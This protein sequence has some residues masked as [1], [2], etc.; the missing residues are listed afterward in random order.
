VPSRL[1][2]RL[3][4]ALV[5]DDA[6]RTDDLPPE[7]ADAVATNSVRQI[8]AMTLQK[9]GDLVVDAK[10]VL[11]WVLAATGAP[12][13]FVGL[14]VP[15]RDAGSMVPQLLL[16]PFVRRLAVRKWVWVVGGL[17][18]AL[19]VVAMAAVTASLTGT[20]AG[21]GILASLLV[22]SLARAASSFA[23][24]DVL[25]RTL[26][27]GIRGQV[28]GLATVGAGIAAVTV[29][30]GLRI[31]GGEETPPSTF[32]WLLL[33]GALAWFLA[34][35]VYAT[36]R[37]APGERDVDT[38]G[39]D[40][41]T[42]AVALLRDDRP[43]RRFVLARSL[44][45][46]SALSPPF[47]VALATEQG[48]AGLEGLAAFVISS[49]VASLVA[50]RFW[51]RA[52]D[53]SSRTTMQWA[54]GLSSV[55]IVAFVAATRVETLAGLTLLYPATYLLLAIAHT[56]SRIGRKTYVVD[57]AEGNKRTDYIAVSNTAMGLILLVA[58]GATAAAASFG[59]EAALL[60]LAGLGV[61]GVLVAASLPEVSAGAQDA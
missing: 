61:L 26:P 50:G 4:G 18:Q 2:E 36:V 46:V 31:I 51:G 34:A 38:R 24:K 20:A 44:L 27:K 22:F 13:G 42:G 23:S 55:I 10:T 58:G 25:G 35:A 7:V 16:A 33:G 37:E 39:S 1:S 6:G 28:N 9:V 21:V 12:A 54:A 30:L 40:A 53:R 5:D 32:A 19:A 49:G 43:F 8:G 11:A 14:L 3:L 17:V 59:P 52:S 47:V 48:G 56:G 45:L 29:G 15:I 41:L 60:L 57:L